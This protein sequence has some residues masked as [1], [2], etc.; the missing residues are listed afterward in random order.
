MQTTVKHRINLN[1]S[2]TCLTSML[3]GQDSLASSKV[4]LSLARPSFLVE[5][6]S[7]SAELPFITSKQFKLASC[8]HQHLRKE[9][10][11]ETLRKCLNPKAA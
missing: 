2:Y 9:K 10:R 6:A 8:P 3:K 4:L 1:L 11:Y 7:S 5:S